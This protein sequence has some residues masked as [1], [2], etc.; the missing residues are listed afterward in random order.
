MEII[1]LKE[2]KE[3]NLNYYFTG[4]PCKRGH[5]SK[6]NLF[7]QCLECI[8]IHSA[9]NGWKQREKRM[10]MPAG[11]YPQKTP[12][13]KY[14]HTGGRDKH[15]YCIECKQLND[16]NKWHNVPKPIQMIRGTKKR[17]KKK[18]LEFNL[19]KEWALANYT[20]KCEITGIEFTDSENF[21]GSIDRIDNSKGYTQENCRF[22]L[23]RVNSIKSVNTDADLVK[24]AER[25]I[26]AKKEGRLNLN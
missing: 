22:I 17:A 19:T 4:K 24:I 13:K 14:G 25:I 16:K 10:L 1:T 2:A 26:Q 20:G 15:G 18:G 9:R 12:C 11:A 7:K 3:K 5:I 23:K 6:R 8:P 21:R